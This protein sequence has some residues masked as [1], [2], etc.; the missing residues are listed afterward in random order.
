MLSRPVSGFALGS[1]IGGSTVNDS[2]SEKLVIGII[3]GIAL[4]ALFL[5]GS[6]AGEPKYGSK[7]EY[8]A[9]V[10]A[11]L[12]PPEDIYDDRQD[13]YDYGRP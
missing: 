7:A 12:E 4:M 13:A 10:E 3:I 11:G 6:G 2:D 9:A 5:W 8:D 1:Q